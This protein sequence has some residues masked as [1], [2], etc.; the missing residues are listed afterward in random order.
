MNIALVC[1]WYLPRIGGI[2]RHLE[3]LADK[4]A[5][6]GHNV[7]VITPTKGRAI[8]KTRLHVQR[9]RALL[10]PR[11]GLMWTPASFRRLGV[12]LR[13][14][15]FDVVHVHCSIISPT[16]FAAVYFAQKAGLP[17]VI[18]GHSILGGFIGAF[19]MLDRVTHWASWPVAF[20]VVSERVAREVRPLVASR[21]VDVLPNAVDPA[22]WRLPLH[23][24]SDH[25]AIACV[26]RL[27]PRKR[28]RVLIRA[29]HAARSQL[30]ST[31]RV[32]LY[33]AGDGSERKSLERLVER[34]RLQDN[35]RFLGSLTPAAVK[36]LL[37]RSHFFVMPSTLEA[38]GIAALEARAAGLPVVAMRSSGV[39]EF[40]THGANGL[41][42][43]NDRDLAAHLLRLCGDEAFR[44]EITRNNQRNPTR[45]T[46]AHTLEAHFTTY[47]RAR[48]LCA[49]RQ[50]MTAAPA[51]PLYPKLGE[52]QNPPL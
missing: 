33:V 34:L 8:A 23:P 44:A 38:F 35:V 6:A 21:A 45:F 47:Q 49:A 12:A 50:T 25:I 18:T 20:S 52:P 1:D 37:G 28:G 40:I 4:L 41:L 42:A 7:T 5:H 36:S 11:V 29:L 13:S 16:A 43:E 24:P 15:R 10:F 2:E 32:C 27:A 19:R 9:L 26:M 48:E 46:W 30:T 22:V 31:R 51:A 3:Q 17:T 14:Q 39:A